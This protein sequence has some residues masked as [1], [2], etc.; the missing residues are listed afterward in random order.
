MLQGV[1]EILFEVIC[2]LTGE[3]IL[4]VVTLGRRKPFETKNPG[5]A[6]TLIGLLFWALVIVAVVMV[7]L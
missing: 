3:V 4:W 6:S 5:Y 1:F 2:A 7:F